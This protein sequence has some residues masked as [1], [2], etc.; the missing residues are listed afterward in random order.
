MRKVAAAWIVSTALLCVRP[1]SAEA[2]TINCD[3]LKRVLAAPSLADTTRIDA[4]LAFVR[5]ECGK[6]LA[7]STMYLLQQ[8]LTLAERLND[9][10]R[11]VD[12]HR[13]KADMH[14]ALNDRRSAITELEKCV[15]LLDALHDPITA[16]AV[17]ME[18]AHQYD[19]TLALRGAW[20]TTKKPCV[21]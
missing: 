12:V 13:A 18:L 2:T 16:E 10:P 7:D 14:A 21:Q 1:T 9:R 20:R 11:Q 19:K 17:H 3:S 5:T 6:D 15:P 4:R 8:A